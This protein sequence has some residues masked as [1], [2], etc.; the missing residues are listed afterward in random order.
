MIVAGFLLGTLF[1]PE[2]GSHIFRRNVWQ[3]ENTVHLTFLF[4]NYLE[5]DT[6]LMFRQLLRFYSEEGSI[7]YK[8]L[9]RSKLREDANLTTVLIVVCG[10]K[11][12]ISTQY[13]SI[14]HLTASVV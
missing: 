7:R 1:D 5:F 2:D 3:S 11:T 6:A 8:G 10:R 13:K 14:F 12:F 4:R 9:C